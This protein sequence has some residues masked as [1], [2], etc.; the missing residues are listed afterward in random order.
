MFQSTGKEAPRKSGS[1][2]CVFNHRIESQDHALLAKVVHLRMS[3]QR[4]KSIAQPFC[5]HSVLSKHVILLE[6]LQRGQSSATSQWI[7]RVGMRVQEATRHAVAVK[8]I[9]DIVSCHH[10]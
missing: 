6:N 8:R 5:K 4:R 7:T 9:I 1:K 2:L 3:G 10:Y